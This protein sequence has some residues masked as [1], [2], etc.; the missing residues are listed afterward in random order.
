MIDLIKVGEKITYYRKEFN[1][2]QDQLSEKLYISRQ[3][4]SKWENGICAPSI[5]AIIDLCKLFGTTFEDLLC[6]EDSLKYDD[7]DIFKGRNRLLVIK[8]IIS[9][10]LKIKLDDIFYL[11]SKEERMIILKAIKD[12]TLIVETSDLY[13]KLT[14]SEQ[15]YLRKEK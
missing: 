10:K 12:Q 14:L 1:L 4:I 13:P 11:L 3:L 15:A 2:T 8:E 7:N 6:L 5:E 9:G